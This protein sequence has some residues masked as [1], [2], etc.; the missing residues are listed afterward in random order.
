MAPRKSR[1]FLVAFTYAVMLALALTIRIVPSFRD[2]FAGWMFASGAFAFMCLSVFSMLVKQ[3]GPLDLRGGELIALGL[4]RRRRGQDQPDE[5]EVAIRN[6]ACFQAYRV[7]ALYSLAVYIAASL[8]FELPT[9]V[10]VRVM[11]V[12]AM[13]LLGMALTLPQAALLW[14]EPDVPEEARV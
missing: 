1:R 10:A 13:P 3:T 14:R 5:R 8:I 7:L 2:R 12:L 4:V 9:S 6:A 11:E